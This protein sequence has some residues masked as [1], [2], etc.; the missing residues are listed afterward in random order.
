MSESSIIDKIAIL[1]QTFDGLT[2]DEL[3]EIAKLTHLREIPALVR[4]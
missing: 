1:H 4:P 3:H 2:E